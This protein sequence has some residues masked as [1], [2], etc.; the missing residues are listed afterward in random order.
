MEFKVFQCHLN[1]SFFFTQKTQRN[2]SEREY[3]P[4]FFCKV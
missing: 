2:V 4:I 3:V 1:W